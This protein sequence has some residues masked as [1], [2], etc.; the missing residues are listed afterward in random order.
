MTSDVLH[1]Q[2]DTP[3]VSTG[4]PSSATPPG[5]ASAM[6]YVITKVTRHVAFSNSDFVGHVSFVIDL[7]GHPC[8]I[9]GVGTLNGD[10]VRFQQKDESHDGRDVRVWQIRGA[11]GAE[12][13]AEHAAAI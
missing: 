9:D 12:F 8:Q 6:P 7:D 4:D 10:G 2:A 3:D 1:Q 5:V 13:V 11:G